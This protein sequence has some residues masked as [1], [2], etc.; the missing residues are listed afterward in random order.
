MHLFTTFPVLSEHSYLCESRQ[1]FLEEISSLSDPVSDGSMLLLGLC[2]LS[3]ELISLNG[4][5]F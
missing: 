1:G 3:I 2:S 4:V 5:E